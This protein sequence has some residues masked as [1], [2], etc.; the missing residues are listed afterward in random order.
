[1]KKVLETLSYLC[2]FKLLGVICVALAILGLFITLNGVYLSWRLYRMQR[3]RYVEECAEDS[4]VASSAEKVLLEK[5][6]NYDYNSYSAAQGTEPCNE[7]NG[8]KLDENTTV[9][10]YRKRLPQFSFRLLRRATANMYLYPES[11]W[12]SLV[13]TR[14]YMVRRHQCS[15]RK[16]EWTCV[17][18]CPLYFGRVVI[19]T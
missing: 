8:S 16:I 4:A 5:P 18:E 6:L 19:F 1:M 3:E 9:G 10:S 14:L 17:S 11:L 13:N 7:L 2:S 12:Q 15:Y